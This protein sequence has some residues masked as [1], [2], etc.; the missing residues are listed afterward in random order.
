MKYRIEFHFFSP[1]IQSEVKTGDKTDMTLNQNKGSE[2][3]VEHR[4]RES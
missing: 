4:R 1:E 2:V 3:E